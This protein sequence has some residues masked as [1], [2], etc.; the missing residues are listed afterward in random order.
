MNRSQRSQVRSHARTSSLGCNA[1]Q[2]HFHALLHAAA[3]F[4][5]NT[6][7]LGLLDRA[8]LRNTFDWVD[9]REVIH[10]ARAADA[11]ERV[12][13]A[14]VVSVHDDGDR[15]LVQLHGVWRKGHWDI[16][17]PTRLQANA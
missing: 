5:F 13:L 4:A 7:G 9:P 2:R 3:S 8:R 6:R 1:G 10:K 14:A 17:S 16:H 11:V 15:G 12:P